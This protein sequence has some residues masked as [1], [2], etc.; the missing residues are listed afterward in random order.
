MASIPPPTL[1]PLAPP[2]RLMMGPGPSNCDSRVYAAMSLPQVGH[3]DGAFIKI[4]DEI[5]AALRYVWHGI[6][7][8]GGRRGNRVVESG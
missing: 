8:R 2:P 5:K 1:G 3:M 7:L 4:V 6:S